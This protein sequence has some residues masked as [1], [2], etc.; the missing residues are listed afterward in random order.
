M[1]VVEYERK[2]DVVVI[3]MDDGKMNSFDFKLLE[4]VG[5]ALDRVDAESGNV[6]ILLMGNAKAFSAGFDLKIMKGPPSEAQYNLF[7]RGCE[8]VIRLAEYHRPVVIG[9]PGHGLALGAI[10]LL[11]G[12]VRVGKR[13]SKF[14]YGMNEVQIGMTVPILGV[15][16]ARHKMPK[17]KFGYATTQGAIVGPDEAVEF[18]FLD[19]CVEE[20]EFQA[21]CY[22]E[23]ERLARLKNP[24]FKN[25]KQY[26][27]GE[28][29]AHIKATLGC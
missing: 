3:T 9:C 8:L 25:T 17:S 1:A 27:R 12:D 28:M 18:G 24:G 15:E 16:L 7:M 20:S 4:A 6:S 26:E 19:M 23:A 14:K 10:L 29:I 5:A 11:A 22:A 2:G 13:G 21:V